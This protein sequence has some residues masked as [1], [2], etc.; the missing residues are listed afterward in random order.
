MVWQWEKR[1][2]GKEGVCSSRGAFRITPVAAWEGPTVTTSSGVRVQKSIVFLG[3]CV[4]CVTAKAKMCSRETG[5]NIQ[6]TQHDRA[7]A[8]KSSLMQN[9]DFQEKEKNTGNAMGN[10]LP[11][12][13]GLNIT[14]FKL[15]LSHL[16]SSFFFLLF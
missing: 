2:S 7:S 14:L 15:K 12:E 1:L 13:Q 5:Q 9:K 6:Q 3:D 11:K 8:E 10:L 4:M 16:P